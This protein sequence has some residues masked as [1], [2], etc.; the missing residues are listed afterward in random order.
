[1]V[2]GYVKHFVMRREFFSPEELRQP[3]VSLAKTRASVEIRFHSQDLL[4]KGSHV[5]SSEAEPEFGIDHIH[6]FQE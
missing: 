6:I 3:V 2:V 4:P 1:M 5:F